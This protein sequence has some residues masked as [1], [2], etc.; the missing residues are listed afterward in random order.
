M[1][2]NSR[3]PRITASLRPKLEAIIERTAEKVAEDARARAPVQSGAL[4]DAI[5]VEDKGDL[6]VHVV[7]GDNT[8]FYGHM[9]EY[10]TSHSPAHPFLIPA[11]EENREEA[12]RRAKRELDL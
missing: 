6:T 5:H 8:A 7:A 4:R 12:I 2:L 1:P 11:L 3:L 10:G 9:V